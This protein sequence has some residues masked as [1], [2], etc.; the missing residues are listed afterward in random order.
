MALFSLSTNTP[1]EE[2]VIETFHMSMDNIRSHMAHLLVEAEISRGHLMCLEEH[3]KVLYE[4]V[5]R[6]GKDLTKAREEVLASLWTSL[7]G[8]RIELG[9]MDLNLDLLKN[10]GKY[11]EKAMAHIVATLETLHV[12]GADMEGLRGKVATLKIAGDRIPIEVQIKS[13]QAG[14]D[15]LKEGQMQA[16]LREGEMLKRVLK[17]EV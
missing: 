16:S 11:K 15:R 13:I 6:N 1:T 10:V 14:V 2:V 3:L 7:G 5:V 12:L 4:L 9:E 17:T 8:N